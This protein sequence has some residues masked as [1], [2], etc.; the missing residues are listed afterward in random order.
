VISQYWF[1]GEGM[2]KA[3]KVAETSTQF[4]FIANVCLSD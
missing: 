4:G 1:L 2:K 3:Q